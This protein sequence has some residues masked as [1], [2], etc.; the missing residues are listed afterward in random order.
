M[1][2]RAVAGWKC[3]SSDELTSG[4]APDLVMQEDS[5]GLRT[6]E[7]VETFPPLGEIPEAR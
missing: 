2:Q 4:P 1:F 7:M 6:L 5:K 3:K